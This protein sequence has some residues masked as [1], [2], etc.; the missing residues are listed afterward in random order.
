MRM[1]QDGRSLHRGL[2]RVVVALRKRPPET[3]VRQSSELH[4]LAYGPIEGKLVA[5]G[6]VSDFR[7]AHRPYDTPRSRREQAGEQLEKC[8]LA[9]TVRS[10][11]RGD[12]AWSDAERN[13]VDRG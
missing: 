7:A 4:H 12:L 3:D 6:E 13:V 5:L 9:R 10:H 2:H 11:E 1:R 8:R